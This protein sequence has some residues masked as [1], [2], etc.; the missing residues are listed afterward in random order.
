MKT[1]SNDVLDKDMKPL[2]QNV[3][4]KQAFNWMK[5]SLKY[6][7]ETERQRKKD[8]TYSSDVP[9]EIGLQLTY[10]CNLRCTH[11]YQ[12]NDEGFFHHYSKTMQKQEV[13]LDVIERLLHATKEAKSR[14]YFWG[15]EPLVYSRWD[16]MC[17]LMENDGRESVICTNAL[18]LREKMDSILSLPVAP[19]LLVSIDGMKDSHDSIRGKGT[20]IKII[21]NI[22]PYILLRQRKKYAGH[23]NVNLVLADANV[24]ELYDIAMFFEN[25]GIDTIYFC[26]PWYIP[27]NV[28]DK[29]D[30][31]FIQ[32]YSWLNPDFI[33]R[34]APASWHSYTHHISPES[35]IILE[36]Q[37]KKLNSKV[38]KTKVRI[39]PDMT[40]SEAEGFLLGTE[41]HAQ[42]RKKCHAVSNRMDILADGT[43]S[44]C[45]LFPEFK[46]GDLNQENDPLKVWKSEEY[47]KLRGI[48][49]QGL[50]PICSKCIQ[51]YLNGI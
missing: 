10:Q 30:E 22:M 29:M 17:K 8:P 4:D 11:C 25:L 46:V 41:E 18:L 3:L 16:E 39:R 5:G 28:A 7:I 2:S 40:L 9:Q 36:E 27:K 50:T 45:K 1:L 51:L 6:A 32:N 35:K 23:I 37:V 19:N 48:M 15:G 31:Y 43:V 47:K 33:N 26:F 44:S 38:W 14:L 21:D 13:A 34:Q 42:N 49:Y 24:P 20:F 12:W